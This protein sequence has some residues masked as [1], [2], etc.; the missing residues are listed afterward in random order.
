MSAARKIRRA[1]WKSNHV[2]HGKRRQGGA[3][4]VWNRQPDHV[5]I[6]KI[7]TKK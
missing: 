1:A 4:K 3:F 6:D 5:A 2:R 7:A